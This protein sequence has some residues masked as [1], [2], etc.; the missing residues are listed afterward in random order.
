MDATDQRDR[1]D[2]RAPLYDARFEHDACGVGFVADAGGRSGSRV[3]PLA[4]AGLGA[5]AH[6]GAFAADGES[7]DGAG[8]ALPL[9]TSL[10]SLIAGPLAVERPGVVMVFLPRG[11]AAGRAARRLLELVFAESGH[12]RPAL[13][14]RAVRAGRAGLGGGFVATDGRAGDRGTPCWRV[15]RGVRAAAGRRSAPAGDGGTVCRRC[16]QRDVRSVGIGSDRRLQGAGRRHPARR[17]L[18][19]SSRAARCAIRRIPPALCD[20]YDAR[21]AAGPAVPL[22]RPQRRDQHG[23]WQP[24][25]GPRAR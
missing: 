4:M 10:L 6:R 19:R 23:P 17:A 22:D 3:L 14:P 25:A 5:L 16:G 13:A 11:R 21:L 15:G 2:L 7:S 24:R 20:E 18:P 9:S 12:A 8:V 1:R